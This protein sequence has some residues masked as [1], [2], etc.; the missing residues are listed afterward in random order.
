MVEPRLTLRTW[1]D[2]S[3][4]P[5]KVIAANLKKRD[6]VNATFESDYE[7]GEENL[8]SLFLVNDLDIIFIIKKIRVEPI[9]RGRGTIGYRHFIGV[10]PCVIDKRE[11]DQDILVLATEMVGKAMSE[12]RRVLRENVDAGSSIIMLREEQPAITRIGQSTLLYGD[13]ARIRW[14]EF[15]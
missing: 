1:F 2:S 8:R 14:D 15:V 7:M 4:A 5:G 10:Q 6:D 9:T 12:V 13:T 3:T 11:A